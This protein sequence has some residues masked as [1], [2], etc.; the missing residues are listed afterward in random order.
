M[1]AETI[2]NG[3]VHQVKLITYEVQI[4][5]TVIYFFTSVWKLMHYDSLAD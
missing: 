2:P 4:A 1:T 5:V 3:I